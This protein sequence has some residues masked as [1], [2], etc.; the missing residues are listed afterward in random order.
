MTELRWILLAVGA[1]VLFAVWLYGRIAKR[2][3]RRP[4]DENLMDAVRD[5]DPP[6][7]NDVLEPGLSAAEIEALGRSLQREVRD[8]AGDDASEQLILTLHVSRDRPIP[9]DILYPALLDEGLAFGRMD[10]FHHEAD[11]G[12][13]EVFS[14]A[15]MVEPGTF[16]PLQPEGFATPGVSLFAVLPG[17]LAGGPTLERLLSCA[18]GLAAEFNATV[19]DETRS[20]LTK[21]T[22][23]HLRER[24]AEFEARQ[25]RG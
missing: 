18:R 10:I 12:A 14:V 9:G 20:A 19:L 25:R 11:D 4:F 16:N 13:G 1:A 6:E 15:N 23:A 24:V 21:Q 2:P 22:E 17:P 3:K 8:D 7:L 5:D